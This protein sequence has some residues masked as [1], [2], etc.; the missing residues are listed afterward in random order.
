MLQSEQL[1]THGCLQSTTRVVDTVPR[2][3]VVD[4][5]RHGQH[6]LCVPQEAARGGASRQ[7][8]QAQRAVPA[9]AQRKL[10]V[11]TDHHVLART[12]RGWSGVVLGS[13]T[14]SVNWLQYCLTELQSLEH[15]QCKLTARLHHPRRL[16]FLNC[17]SQCFNNLQL[18]LKTY[19]EIQT[20][21][22]A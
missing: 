3:P 4:G 11:G 9:T 16:P 5:E 6:I 14:Q 17:T 7:V 10:A 13:A 12:A 21:F 18:C 2:L 19:S 15:V 20:S 8:P 1:A 22:L